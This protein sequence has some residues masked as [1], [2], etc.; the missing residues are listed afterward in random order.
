MSTPHPDQLRQIR[1]HA[2]STFVRQL[3]AL[4]FSLGL[5]VVASRLLLPA[6]YGRFTLATMAVVL[7]ANV[8]GNG[9]A[10]GLIREIGSSPEE[11]RKLTRHALTVAALSGAVVAPFVFAA[12]WLLLGRHAHPAAL[13]A[14]ALPMA[15]VAAAASGCLA[16]RGLVRRWNRLQM[17]TAPLP[18][19]GVASCVFVSHDRLLVAVAGWAV[20]ETLTALIWLA[21][22]H[23]LVRP[24]R[25]GGL[26]SSR[27]RAI[28]TVAVGS[29]IAT[30]V[31]QLNYRID[32]L[33]LQGVRGSAAVGIYAVSVTIAELI[34]L[35]SSAFNTPSVE[36]VISAQ[37]DAEAARLALY[38]SR[39]SILFA[40]VLAALIAAS[41]P[42]A[43]P[44]AFGA[45][46][47]GAVTPL[48]VLLIPTV[49]FAGGKVLAV[50]ITMRHGNTK[51]PLQ[52]GCWACGATIL[53]SLPGCWW[54]GASGAAL[55][56]GCG[57]LIGISIMA[58]GFAKISGCSLLEI[59]PRQA[60]LTVG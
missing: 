9:L 13:A 20:A 41:A 5:G 8:V 46:F 55:A 17:L 40:A 6:G 16:A 11:T 27:G 30:V 7:V 2:A 44:A 3:A 4:P 14:A 24:W 45:R 22:V 36:P 57:Y 26:R 42:F 21:A 33:V 38:G 25:G 12:L 47:A 32:M 1:R 43:I 15:Q 50:Y 54:L 48:L 53:L 34:W 28:A 39:L 31:A 58:R 51:L 37:D 60:D 59:I 23:P 10:V 52:A 35:A 56:S 29:G 19:V 49:L 18:L